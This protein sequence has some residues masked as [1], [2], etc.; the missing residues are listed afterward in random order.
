MASGHETFSCLRSKQ[1]FDSILSTSGDKLVVIYFS[2]TWCGPCRSISPEFETLSKDPEIAS[3]VVFCK[4]DVDE[5]SEI[6]EECEV[7]CMPTFCFF[8]GE[9]KIYQFS[10]GNKGRLREYIAKYK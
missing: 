9:S 5:A 1:D 3:N 7:Q 6:A 8:R 10:G 4:A 2:A